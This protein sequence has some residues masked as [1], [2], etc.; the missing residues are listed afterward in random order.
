ML[1]QR[2]ARRIHNLYN[3]NHK[4]TNS[5]SPNSQIKLN[6]TNLRNNYQS[7]HFSFKSVRQTYSIFSLKRTTTPQR[8]AQPP[9]REP[10]PQTPSTLKKPH[11]HRS[12]RRSEPMQELSTLRTAKQAVD[13]GLITQQDFEAVK[14]GFL[15]AQRI[16]AGLDA[17]FIP[18][19]DFAAASAAFF[20]SL[21]VS[22]HSNKH[23]PTPQPARKVQNGGASPFTKPSNQ[24]VAARQKVTVA[25][26]GDAKPAGLAQR[27]NS[28]PS[29]A[30][31]VVPT[32]KASSRTTIAQPFYSAKRR[33]SA[34]CWT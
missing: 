20:E 27:V 10:N 22:G 7:L 5:L 11:T 17:G 16:K 31:P 23:Q 14:Q 13:E 2:I 4:V 29:P 1:L 12:S 18:E 33:L 6:Q 34:L 19:E 15:N 26:G 32:A 3:Q 30:K 9:K 28:L 24:P 21:G 25:H 8:S